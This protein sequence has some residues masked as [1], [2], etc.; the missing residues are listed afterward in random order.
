LNSSNTINAT[1]GFDSTYFNETLLPALNADYK[2]EIFLNGDNRILSINY[3]VNSYP[4]YDGTYSV[5]LSQVSQNAMIGIVDNYPYNSYNINNISPGQGFELTFWDQIGG[6]NALDYG[7][8]R[9]GTE[10]FAASSAA[11]V[12]EPSTY[13]LFGIGAIGLLVVLQRKKTA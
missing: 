11:S 10:I 5:D 1:N 7:V 13:A 4:G 2:A 3:T 12:P 8:I 6:L 9:V